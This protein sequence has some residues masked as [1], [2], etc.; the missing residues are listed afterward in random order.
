M[1]E[2]HLVETLGNPD[3]SPFGYP[4]P[5]LGSASELSMTTLT[6]VPEGETV[7]VERVFEEDEQLLQF[8]DAEGI[9]PRAGGEAEVLGAVPRDGHDHD[10]GSRDRDGDAGRQPRLGTRGRGRV[11]AG[12]THPR[13]PLGQHCSRVRGE[14]RRMR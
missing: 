7:A 11:D 13:T 4:I 5:G 14:A 8:F 2:P 9:R 12:L 3:R 1:T 6:D 10:R